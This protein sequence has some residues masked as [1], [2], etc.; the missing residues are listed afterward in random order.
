MT[1]VGSGQKNK[2]TDANCDERR[3]V[4]VLMRIVLTSVHDDE[5]RNMCQFRLFIY[6][7]WKE[8]TTTST[9]P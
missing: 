3:L 8:H 7:T 2:K 9:R 4:F 1:A 6:R 5:A